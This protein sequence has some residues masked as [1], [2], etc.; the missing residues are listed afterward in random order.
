[1]Q[2]LEDEVTLEHYPANSV[3]HDTLPVVRD[4]E[5]RKRL[6]AW[7]TGTT[8]FPTIDAAMRYYYQYGWLN[9]RS[10]A[11]ITSFAV[12]ALRL[13]WQL[14]QYELAKFMIDYVP[15]IN[16]TQVQ[17]QTGVTG[18]NTIRVYSPMKQMIDHD[19]EAI[20]IKKHIPELRSFQVAEIA[21]FETVTLGTYPRPIIDFKIETKLMK[22]VLY[23][24]K[25]SP[26]GRAVAKQVYQKHGSRKRRSTE[27]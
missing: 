13:P 23:A 15:G 3:F 11:M 27:K 19:P 14:V 4:D 17:M 26:P 21:K 20:F 16:T 18:M 12:H 25:K 5:L 7:K 8:G 10:R 22:D 2:K 24:L 1:M 6:L 9:F